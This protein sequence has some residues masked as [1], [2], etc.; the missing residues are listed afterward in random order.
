MIRSGP[1]DRRRVALTFGACSTYAPGRYDARVT[2]ALVQHSVPATTFLGGKWME[3][4]A[5]NTRELARNPRFELANHTFL[6]PHMMQVSYERAQRELEW[7]QA[8]LFTLTGRRARLF[9]PPFGEVDERIAR[10]AG[11]LGLRTVEYDLASGDP[12]VHFTRDV[13]VKYASETARPGSIVVMHINTRG[14]HTAEALPGIAKG[15]RDRGF[16]LVTVGELIG[17]ASSTSAR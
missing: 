6:H 3:E 5:D 17:L 16:E 11:E 12:D 13:L 1:R 7:T 4:N 8:V 9:R 2:A 14:W 10:I 15:L